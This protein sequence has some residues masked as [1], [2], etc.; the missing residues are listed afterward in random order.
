MADPIV[1]PATLT[2]GEQESLTELITKGVR[3]LYGDAIKNKWIFRFDVAFEGVCARYNIRSNDELKSEVGK[4]FARKRLE[5]PAEDELRRRSTTNEEWLADYEKE[6]RT[7]S[8][9]KRNHNP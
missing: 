1:D 4:R 2:K 9:K 7:P 3:A 5:A 6:E 8:S